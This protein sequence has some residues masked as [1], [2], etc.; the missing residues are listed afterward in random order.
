MQNGSGVSN[1]A[2]WIYGMEKEAQA[3]LIFC[4]I[5]TGEAMA[6]VILELN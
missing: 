5:C 3:G 1:R 4:E 6:A 2:W